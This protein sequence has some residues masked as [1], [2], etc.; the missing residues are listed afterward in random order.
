MQP[1]RGR[2]NWPLRLGLLVAFFAVSAG[3]FVL[4]DRI[5][6]GQTPPG[7]AT[8][9]A[10]GTDP[11]DGDTGTGGQGQTVDGIPCE[12]GERLT[13]HV[14]AHLFILDDG[15]PQPVS[16]DVGIPGAPLVAKCI[17]WVHTHDRTGAIHVE[18]PGPR[19]FTLGQFFDIWGQPLTSSKVVRILVPAGQFEVFLNGQVY[20][21]DPRR[22][23]LKAH[24][25][26]VIEIGKRVIPP[27][28]D[29]RSL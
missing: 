11:G 4:V 19:T 15:V 20:S 18:S 28:F 7:P 2:P 23:E 29:F 10:P 25:Q 8:S 27:T 26:V 21:G 3:G 17:Y 13:F 6:V 24:T 1:T 22:I 16:A 14:H 5:S 12:H 9:A